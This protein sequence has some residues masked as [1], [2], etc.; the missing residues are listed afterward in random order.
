MAGYTR[1]P[2]LSDVHLKHTNYS[3]QLSKSF[4]KEDVFCWT[5]NVDACFARAG[6]WAGALWMV[7]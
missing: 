3:T 5:S 7:K 6:E 2:L 4:G 1:C